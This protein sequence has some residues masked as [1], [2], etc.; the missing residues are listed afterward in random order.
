[1]SRILRLEPASQP[2]NLRAEPENLERVTYRSKDDRQTD[3]GWP[4]DPLGGLGLWGC[5]A[6]PLI[7]IG[8][9]TGC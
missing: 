2:Q 5:K 7:A 4:L 3:R 1:M 8:I 6:L 9:G